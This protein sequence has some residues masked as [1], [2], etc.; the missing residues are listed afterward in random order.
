MKFSKYLPIAIRNNI[1]VVV[2]LGNV[3]AKTKLCWTGQNYISEKL[4]LLYHKLEKKIPKK[5]TK[6]MDIASKF[7][8]DKYVKIQSTIYLIIN[9]Y[10][11]NNG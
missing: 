10:F 8:A 1:Y 9:S 7:L 5:L 6:N 11:F 4:E 2:V 3:L